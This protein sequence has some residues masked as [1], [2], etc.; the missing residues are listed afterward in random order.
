MLLFGQ[1][2]PLSPLATLTSDLA[3][4]PLMLSGMFTAIVGMIPVEPLTWLGGLVVWLSA[5]WLLWWVEWWAAI[6]WAALPV[7][8]FNQAYAV[9]CYGALFAA[10]WLFAQ[11]ERRATLAS[12]WPRIQVATLGAAAAA[13][14]IIA[15]LLL[16]IRW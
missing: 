6:P 13:L 10:V 11:A 7:E 4:L 1:V 14:W 8:G 3:L 5:G 15:I 9:A 2:S 16:V 12:L